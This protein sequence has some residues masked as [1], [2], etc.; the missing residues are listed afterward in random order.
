MTTFESLMKDPSGLTDEQ[1]LEIM[2]LLEVE[3]AKRN[4][5]TPHKI[6]SKQEE[7]K[8]RK[9]YIPCPHCG[10]IGTIK[11]GKTAA[12]TQRYKCKDCHKTFTPT[13]NTLFQNSRLTKE[14]W[15]ELLRG[16]IEHLSLQKI[17]DNIQM[18]VK[19]AWYNKHKVQ[20]ALLEIYGDQD[21]FA[22][23]VECDECTTRLSFKG[24]KDPD[25]FINHLGRLPKHHRS[26]YEK[27]EYLKKNGLMGSIR[28]DLLSDTL[29]E[30]QYLKGSNRDRV[31]ILTATDRSSNLYMKPT[32]LGN[33]ESS[34]I[35]QEFEG[36]FNS[37]AI[38]VSDG[39]NAY[40]Q[41]AEE[42]N[43][44]HVQVISKDHANG[45]YSLSRL[46]SIHS[47]YRDHYHKGGKNLLATKYLDLG[48]MFF[49]WQQKNKDLTT[50]QQLEEL[51]ACISNKIAAP[52]TYYGLRNRPL[53]LDTK[54]LIPEFV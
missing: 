44:H 36:R 54:R 45:P 19:A 43:I 38:M 51:F 4:I 8:Q 11:C 41:F 2:S 3:K 27:I 16:M 9:E 35:S 6:Q 5:E 49:W 24:K 15:K 31:C 13:I 33:I 34:H 23:I 18:S 39:N 28:P 17:A 22:D 10:S 26:K 46:N 7:P 48:I 50:A 47:N 1:I 12:G 20:S 25:F 52:I 53:P 42:N 40:I 30:Q 14:Q 32:C 21:T 37:D 29:N